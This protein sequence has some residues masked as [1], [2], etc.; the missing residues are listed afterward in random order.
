MTTIMPTELTKGHR[1]PSPR[2]EEGP[3]T[4]VCDF[5]RCTHDERPTSIHVRDSRGGQFFIALPDD[6][7]HICDTPAC[8]LDRPEVT[9]PRWKGDDEPVTKP[10][11]EANTHL[12]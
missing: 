5:G 2:L 10:H 11:A 6:P 12:R 9:M 4:A 3:V 1:F 8:W 7:I